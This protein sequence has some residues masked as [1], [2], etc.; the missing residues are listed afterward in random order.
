MG[1]LNTA[2]DP[3]FGSAAEKLRAAAEAKGIKTHYISGVRSREDQEQL[4]A[5]YIAGKRGQPL[6]YP[7]RG[8]VPLAAVPGTS[9]HE[10]GLAADIAADDP[11]QEAA[12]WA[13]APQFGLR[14]IGKSDPNHFEMASVS[15]QPANL[16]NRGTS[17]QA[18]IASQPSSGSMTHEQFIRDYA[19]KIGL[20][21]DVAVGVANAE[22]LRAWS[23]QNPNAGSYID[24]TA[25]VPWS[26]GDF[27]LNTRN[28]MGV[29]AQKAGIDPK[30][31]NQWQAADKFAL[32]QMKSV[33]LGPWKGDAFAK[34]WGSKPIGTSINSTP[35]PPDAYGYSAVTGPT[36]P[37]VAAA[38]APPTFGE[39]IKSGDIGGAFKAALTKPPPKKDAQGNDVAQ[40]SPLEKLAAL[41]EDDKSQAPAAPAPAPIMPAQDPNPG[42]APAA[43]QLF[44]TV[45]AA[46]AKP[47]SWNSR[48]YGYNA[49]YQGTTLNQTGYG[50]G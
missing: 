50:N 41:G 16:L 7:D 21:P 32:D 6:P 17:S 13:M 4:Y 1:E 5:N 25:G 23:P 42:L 2:F 28:G 11:S 47:L 18:P 37:A 3:T 45:S 38:P 44:S 15:R 27:Q 49:G 9:L 43:Q 26:F 29:D 12:L 31:P 46:A 20:N 40:K 34:G 24:R 22:G 33:G 30:D 10:R 39:A 14:A 8:R 48:P 35:P 36:A 19:A